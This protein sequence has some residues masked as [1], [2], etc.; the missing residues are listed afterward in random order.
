MRSI[1]YDRGHRGSQLTAEGHAKVMDFGLAKVV[2]QEGQTGSQTE[3]DSLLTEPGA[4]AGTVPY[5]PPEQINGEGLDGRSDIFSFGV[6]LYEM[7]SGHHPFA[8][9]SMA[10]TI[11]AIL[12]R[13][14]LPLAQ[15][16]PEA[17][18]GLQQIVSKAL[19]KNR[20]E[21]YQTTTDLLI[22]LN[23]LKHTLESRGELAQFRPSDTRP[24][25]QSAFD[26]RTV[27][28]RIRKPRVAVPAVGM[29]LLNS[30]GSAWFFNRQAR[31]R[32]SGEVALP[33][34]QLSRPLR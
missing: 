5:M 31:V 4:V 10:A 13:E 16:T 33:A 12:T 28:L 32:W 26:L 7:L 34:E 14:P 21:R 11:S 1:S 6:I 3:T 25:E 8:S 29:I 15:Y 20:D 23:S 19:N 9:K 2:Q 17:L 30:L 27:L 24:V 18:D 22:D